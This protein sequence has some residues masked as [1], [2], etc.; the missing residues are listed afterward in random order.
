MHNNYYKTLIQF[1]RSPNWDIFIQILLHQAAEYGI[2]AHKIS[3]HLAKGA[4]K[5][6][7]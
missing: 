2:A 4:P 6:R 3:R 1:Q 7:D 5:L